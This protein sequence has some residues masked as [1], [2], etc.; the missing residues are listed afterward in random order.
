MSKDKFKSNDRPKQESPNKVLEASEVQEVA[1]ENETPKPKAAKVR[2]ATVVNCDMLRVRT[3]ATTNADV[4]RTL[5]R[6]T[7]I[8]VEYVK[9]GWAALPNK[10]GFVMEKFLK[11]HE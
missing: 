6:G 2:K 11:M 5:K 8:E 1:V 10:R 4:V 3:G 9:E 7:E